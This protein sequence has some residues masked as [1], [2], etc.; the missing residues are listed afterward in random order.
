MFKQVV[1]CAL[2]LSAITVM[3]SAAQTY[4]VLYNF[5]TGGNDGIDPI[6][7]LVRDPSGNLYGVTV[8]GGASGVGVVY[9]L[10]P[11]GNETV[12][13]DFKGK[14]DAALPRSGLFRDA[15]GNLFG[16][17]F[18]GGIFGAKNADGTVFELTH[19]GRE[20]VLHRFGGGTD[21]SGPTSALV[22][23]GQ[24]NLYGATGL[25]GLTGAGTIYRTTILH[26]FTGTDGAIP[27][28]GLVIDS[29]GNVY[30]STLTG[31]ANGYG[32]VFKVAPDGTA[33]ALY[34]FCSLPNC[35]DGRNPQAC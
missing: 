4:T 16:A 20:I 2:F 35:T 5:Q 12:L 21:G 11:G 18:Q 10:A 14:P 13:Y 3:P 29:H 30:G 32:A 6:G 23:D 17:T 15:S 24:G 1:W 25:G 27:V 19:T 9:K 26:S 7:T 28:D 22:P 33:T 34:S 31:G 8:V